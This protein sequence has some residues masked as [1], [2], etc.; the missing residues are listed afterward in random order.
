MSPTSDWPDAPGPRVLMLVAND[1][2]IDTRVRKTASSVARAGYSVIAIGVDSRGL[3][4]EEESLDGARLVRLVPEPDPRL[5]PNRVRLSR[6]ELTESLRYRAEIRKQRLHVARRS[7][8]ADVA[9]A[10]NNP[11]PW[12]EGYGRAAAA[13]S[14][15]LGASEDTSTKIGRRTTRDLRRIWR[16]FRF[17]PRR[18][19]TIVSQ[20]VHQA[21]VAGSRALARPS[22]PILRSP[23]WRRDLPELHHFEAAVGPLIDALEPD[24]VHVHDIFL[25]GVAARAK[26]RAQRARRELKLV[27][28]AHEYVPGLPIEERRREALTSL[29]DE[30]CGR[31]DQVI[32]VSPGLAELTAARFGGSP[33]VVMNAPDTRHRVETPN[34]RT[35][36]SIPGGAPLVVYVGGIAPHRGAEVLVDAVARLGESV[37]LVFVSNSTTG[38]VSDLLEIARIKGVGPRVHIAPYVPSEAVVPYIRTATVSA[39]PLS[40]QYMNYEIALPNKLFQSIHAGVPVA[41]S[42]NPEMARFVREHGVGEVFTGDDPMSLASVLEKMI[43]S[44]NAYVDE[45]TRPDLLESISWRAQEVRLLATYRS[46]GV[47]AP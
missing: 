21:L 46:L 11:P 47:T 12:L 14:R 42:D 38:Y 20:F 22:R 30:Y 32:T 43:E 10:A 6:P 3:S 1:M 39:V 27:Y 28:D 26:A 25:L 18:A 40:R 35:I 31:A 17:S 34:L 8:S 2:T 45:L 36:L 13:A 44:P 5:S 9:E 7:L 33:V 19:G 15:R 23:H 37:H 24:L 29:E 41:V 4:P 16:W